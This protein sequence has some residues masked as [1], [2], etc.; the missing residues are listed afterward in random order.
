[1]HHPTPAAPAHALILTLLMACGP[2]LAG[3][4]TGNVDGVQAGQTQPTAII[5][6][7]LSQNGDNLTG[8]V[9]VGEISAGLTGSLQGNAIAPLVVTMAPPDRCPG[10]LQ[11]S[12]VLSGDG[13]TLTGLVQGNTLACGELTLRFVV[14]QVTSN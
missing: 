14:S 5:L 2:H 11:G 6:V 9:S 10:I 3:T 13:K 1:M 4:W 7:T 12:A 8:T